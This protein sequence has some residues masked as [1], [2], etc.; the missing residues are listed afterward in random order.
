MILLVIVPSEHNLPTQA[1]LLSWW[2]ILIIINQDNISL[3]ASGELLLLLLLLLSP[4]EF[5]AELLRHTVVNLQGILVCM[6]VNPL[7]DDLGNVLHTF[8]PHIGSQVGDLHPGVDQPGVDPVRAVTR[9]FIG[10]FVLPRHDENISPEEQTVCCL[11]PRP[12]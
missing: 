5:P 8:K 6:V 4:R 3:I 9:N 1:S 10:K 11:A 7:H 2:R 12:T